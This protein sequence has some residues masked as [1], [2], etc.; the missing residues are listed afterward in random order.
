MKKA[1][2][3]KQLAGSPA[4]NAKGQLLPGATAN[5]GGRP[6]LPD[7]FKLK[8]PALLERMLKIAET[9]A[10]EHNYRAL[11]WCCERIYGKA[12]QDVDVAGNGLTPGAAALMALVQL[13]RG[14][15]APETTP[16]KRH[17]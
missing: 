8:G 6:S 16:A 3:K 11:E 7:D 4:R 1:K 13:R 5:P 2:L 14:E 17:E 9:E 10:H 12:R 15:A